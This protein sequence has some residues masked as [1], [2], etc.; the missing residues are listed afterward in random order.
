[1]SYYNLQLYI[2]SAVTSDIHTDNDENATQ[3]DIHVSLHNHASSVQI[4]NATE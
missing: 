3:C 4:G 2:I 1:M